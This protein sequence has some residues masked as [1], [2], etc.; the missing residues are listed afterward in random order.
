MKRNEEIAN[1]LFFRTDKTIENSLFDGTQE[2]RLKKRNN[3]EK[4]KNFFTSDPKFT[5]N[6]IITI[7]TSSLVAAIFTISLTN[8]KS[9]NKVDTNESNISIK[10]KKWLLLEKI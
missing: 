1:I 7:L 2:A 10:A 4:I 6:L 9:S 3:Y 5:I 8:N